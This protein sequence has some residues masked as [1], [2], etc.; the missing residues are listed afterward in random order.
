[1]VHQPV[2]AVEALLEVVLQ[3]DVDERGAGC[4]VLHE[5]AQVALHDGEVAGRE[6]A[7]QVVDVNADL[8]V[9]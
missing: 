6:V 2:V 5:G 4:G 8:E 9:N 1:M 7:G 3:R